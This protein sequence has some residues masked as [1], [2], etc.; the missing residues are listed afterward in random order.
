MR[1]E[2]QFAHLQAQILAPPVGAGDGLTVERGDRWVERLEH[3]QGCDVDATD[4]QPD[5]VTA[6]VVGKRFDLG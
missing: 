2:V 4:G 1:D 6:E 3:G 5:G